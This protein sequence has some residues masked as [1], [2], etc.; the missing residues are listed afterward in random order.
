[1]TFAMY[2]AN[3]LD[4]GK[5]PRNF[6]AMDDAT[7][8]MERNNPL[9]GDSI[10]LYFKIAS[11]GTIADVSFTGSGCTISQA[12]TS[13][14]TEHVK[15]KTMEAVRAMGKQDV[16]ELLGAPVTP[17]REKCATLP[18]DAVQHSAVFR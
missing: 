12:A 15:G 17:A 4:H 18:L 9:C 13:L 16:M 6:H 14:F 1:M 10:V 2:Q 8:H 5:H 7:L 11:D 3:V